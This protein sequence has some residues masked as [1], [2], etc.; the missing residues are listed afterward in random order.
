VG[1]SQEGLK[2]SRQIVFDLPPGE[3]E[4]R[5]EV[6]ASRAQ[7]RAELIRKRAQ[8]A[9]EGLARWEKRL[10]Y[11]MRKLVAYQRTV[12]YYRKQGVLP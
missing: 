1:K 3:A 6:Q 11:A 10:C 7:A 9:L 5:A 8:R 2:S 12:N 4:R